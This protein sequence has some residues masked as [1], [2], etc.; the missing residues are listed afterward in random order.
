LNATGEHVS[1]G[2]LERA[3][4]RACRLLRSEL[5]D[6]TVLPLVSEAGARHVYYMEFRGSAPD[7]D[8][9]AR[10]IDEDVAASNGDYSAHRSSSAGLAA[11]VIRL[12]RSG[13]FHDFMRVRGKLGGQHKVP[14][15]LSRAEDGK[16]FEA[17]SAAN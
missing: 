11:P 2:E 6:F 12:V 15:V 5:G 7:L 10:L 13:A 1:Q 17:A 4:S 8:E 16:W 14:R 3:V 9:L